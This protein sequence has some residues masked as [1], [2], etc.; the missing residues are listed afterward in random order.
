MLDSNH[1]FTAYLHDTHMDYIRPAT[2]TAPAYMLLSVHLLPST[3]LHILYTSCIA[4]LHLYPASAIPN[5][6]V[7][8]MSKP[9]TSIPQS[10]SAVMAPIAARQFCKL[11]VGPHHPIAGA[12][13]VPPAVTLKPI[14]TP[15]NADAWAQ[16]LHNHPDQAF[17]AALVDEIRHSFRI[18]LM[19]ST[20]CHS[21]SQN[22][23]SAW[24]HEDVV[25]A[26]IAQQLATG[27]MTGPFLHPTAQ[28]LSLA[29]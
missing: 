3:V 15:L 13:G 21:S 27:F 12:C 4:V 11:Q 7:P 17:V 1:A 22:F 19:P 26:F 5:C 29:I 16:A 24:E 10:T 23:P 25:D 9:T 18:G 8:S 6:P 28:V 14:A 2:V 20:A